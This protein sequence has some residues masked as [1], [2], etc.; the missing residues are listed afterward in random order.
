MPTEEHGEEA[1]VGRVK[2]GFNPWERDSKKK[3]LTQQYRTQKGSS[4]PLAEEA[5]LGQ[6]YLPEESRVSQ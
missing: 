3:R 4:K 5:V 6:N 1:G 2:D